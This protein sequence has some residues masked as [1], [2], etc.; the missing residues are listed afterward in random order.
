MTIELL[1]LDMDRYSLRLSG[2]EKRDLQ[3]NAKAIAVGRGAVILSQARV[4]DRIIFLSEGIAASEQT[5]S[6]GKSTIARFFE[7]RD[8]CTNVSSAWTGEIAA[9]ELIAITDVKG[10]SIS[11]AFFMREYIQGR[12]FGMYLR[13]R[14]MEAHL[15]AKE[16]A[17]AKTSGNTKTRHDFLRT[18]HQRVLD[19][20]PQKEIAKFLG[21]TA[22]GLSRFRRNS[23][24]AR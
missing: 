2:D 9:D 20:V 17:C 1:Q 8:L 24:P 4:A 12:E 16:L 3:R 22:Q 11:L 19:Q 21:V 23:D 5:W 14:M 15:F 10:L 7:P 13:H 6:D 18:H